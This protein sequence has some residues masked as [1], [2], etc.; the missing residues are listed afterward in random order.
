MITTLVPRSFLRVARFA[1]AGLC[2]V[3]AACDGDAEPTPADRFCDAASSA[4]AADPLLS[5]C[6]T[7]AG[8]LNDSYLDA[9]ATCTEAGGAPV[10]CLVSEVDT[11]APSD[12]H[13]SLAAAF[14]SECA[15]GVSGCEDL[16][17]GGGE[18]DTALAGAIVVPLSDGLVQTIEAECASGLTCAATFVSCAQEQIVAYGLP[19][20]TA[21]CLV[22]RVFLGGTDGCG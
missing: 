1:C 21:T 4:A 10:D 6:G 17:F 8:V 11:L 19:T 3:A 18:D 9:A 7:V 16:F 13:R 20:E 22:E 5:D 12:A 2:L 14:C 15:L